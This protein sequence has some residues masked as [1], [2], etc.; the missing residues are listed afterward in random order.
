MFTVLY[1]FAAFFMLPNTPTSARFFTEAEK[2]II[3]RTLHDDGIMLV[4]EHD[5]DYTWTEFGRAFLQPHVILIALS[6]FFNGM[7][8][9]SISALQS[10]SDFASYRCDGF[11]TSIV[12]SSRI[13]P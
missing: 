9:R 2:S 1:G 6:G 8:I 10:H 7:H 3:R 11:G 5:K 12:R 13:I 4:D